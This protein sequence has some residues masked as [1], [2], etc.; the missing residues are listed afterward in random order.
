MPRVEHKKNLFSKE[1]Q[2]KNQVGEAIIQNLIDDVSSIVSKDE[3]PHADEYDC[4]PTY[5]DQ[6]ILVEEVE[7][8]KERVHSP[9]QHTAISSNI[10]DLLKH[11]DRI[12]EDNDYWKFMGPPF[13]DSSRPGSIVSIR[14]SDK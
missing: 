3:V 4:D 6:E 10:S 2:D 1:I 5:E 12:I 7:E 9:C 11:N 14:R 8:Q 13:Y